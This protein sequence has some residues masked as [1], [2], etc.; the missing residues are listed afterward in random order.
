MLFSWNNQWTT[1][2]VNITINTYKNKTE[3][4]I[5]I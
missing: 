2:N 3:G 4:D 5:F 1:G